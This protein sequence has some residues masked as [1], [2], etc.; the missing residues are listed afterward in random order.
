M[1]GSI[2]VNVGIRTTLLS[3]RCWIVEIP[4]Y[5][6]VWSMEWTGGPARTTLTLA[7][8]WADSTLHCRAWAANG[9]RVGPYSNE[10]K[11][12]TPPIDW[13]QPLPIPTMG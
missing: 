8:L 6:P 3:V 11:F 2:V 4:S 12:V 5:Q 9:V 1:Q 13:S 7:N 10:V